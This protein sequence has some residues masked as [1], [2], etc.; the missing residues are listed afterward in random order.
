MTKRATSSPCR[1]CASKKQDFM[2]HTM[3]FI[4]DQSY[5]HGVPAGMGF[6][7]G[8]V[9]MIGEWFGFAHFT[10]TVSSSTLRI[11]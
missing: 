7:R 8:S 3:A 11:V 6:W 2:V 4:I 10:T 1:S 9:R 5:P